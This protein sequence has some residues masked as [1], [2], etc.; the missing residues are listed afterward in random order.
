MRSGSS[1]YT[2][3]AAMPGRPARSACSSAP[4][5]IRPARLVLTSSAPGFMRARS[6]AVTMPRVS[7]TSRMCSDSTSQASKKAAL[8][9]AV[10][11][12]SSRARWREASRAQT[13][14]FM[15]KAAP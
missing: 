12:P 15:P 11:Q 2:S 3:T 1:S 4:G 13:S 5:A 8:S 14:T 7:F 9:G 10:S 6:S